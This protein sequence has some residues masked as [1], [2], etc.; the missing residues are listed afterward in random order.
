MRHNDASNPFAFRHIFDIRMPCNPL[1]HLAAP[2]NERFKM[3]QRVHSHG[4]LVLPVLFVV[5]ASGQGE[6]IGPVLLVV[7][8]RPP[9]E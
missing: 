6:Q 2:Q 7:K 1:A 3:L 4:Q 5:D 9:A 8:N